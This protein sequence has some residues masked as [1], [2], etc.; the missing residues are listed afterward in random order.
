MD[1]EV[2]DSPR[3]EY[4]VLFR[5]KIATSRQISLLINKVAFMVWDDSGEAGSQAHLQGGWIHPLAG[6]NAHQ[7]RFPAVSHIPSPG[8]ETGTMLTRQSC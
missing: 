4:S 1:G 5:R 3:I 8:Q 7:G 2:R 6:K